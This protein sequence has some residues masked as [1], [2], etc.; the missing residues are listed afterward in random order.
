MKN[1]QGL[2]HI[3]IF[4]SHNEKSICMHIYVYVP[5]CL[6]DLSFHELGEKGNKVRHTVL[7]EA[8]AF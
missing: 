6:T 3:E 8:S 4:V 7:S 2:F 5:F 1:F